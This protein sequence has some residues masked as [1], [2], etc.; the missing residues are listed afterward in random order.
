MS[1]AAT[2]EL[3][4]L[5]AVELKG[6]I[7]GLL[8]HLTLRQT[9]HNPHKV[10][11]ELTHIFPLPPR[12]AVVSCRLKTGK[13]Y[14]SGQLMERRQARQSF[15]AHATRGKTV[16]T[17]E[18]DR[19]DLYTL[20][21]GPIAPGGHLEVELALDLILATEREEVVLS[22]PLTAGRR[23]VPGRPSHGTSA[24]MGTGVDTDI[25]ADASRLNPPVLRP[26][27]SEDSEFHLD[28]SIDS[29]NHD[30]RQVECH[31]HRLKISRR[32]GILRVKNESD[33]PARDFVLRLGMR[34]ENRLAVDPNDATF[35]FTPFWAEDESQRRPLVILLDRSYAMKGQPLADALE[36]AHRLIDS[37]EPEQSFGLLS[38]AN[39]PFH[40][41]SGLVPA[42]PELKLAA[43]Q[44]LQE[45]MAQPG[46]ELCQGLAAVEV[47]LAG[48][49]EPCDLVLLTSAQFG[50]HD[51]LISWAGHQEGLRLHCVA[52]G[53]VV[54]SGLLDRLCC[55]TGGSS[56]RLEHPER[57]DSTYQDL[58]ETLTAARLS[59]LCLIG[60]PLLSA[61]PEHWE[62]SSGRGGSF[63]GRFTEPPTEPLEMIGTLPDGGESSEVITPLEFTHPA[64]PASW[65]RAR[66]LDLEDRWA[67]LPVGTVD[68]TVGG[69]RPAS[70]AAT[71]LRREAERGKAWLER[72]QDFWR[73]KGWLFPPSDQGEPAL[74]LVKAM[75]ESSCMAYGPS[76]VMPG[77][78]P[79][80]SLEE[81]ARELLSLESSIRELSIERGVLCRFT[82]YVVTTGSKVKETAHRVVVPVPRIEER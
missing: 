39:S 52:V 49:S 50:D 46:G 15:Q 73:R 65:A 20:R 62:V 16:C 42:I 58:L 71:H 81:Q 5:V 36:I 4:L 28:L 22:F 57:L 25:V 24:G 47:L 75:E 40:F 76:Q 33:Q 67:G 80:E 8:S 10:P 30:L 45:L 3:P 56:H 68:L 78:S 54:N 82:A 69:D 79:L 51:R 34:A 7:T 31:T 17:L 53:P 43:H 6:R 35:H 74:P 48:K 64:I 23:Y 13:R 14:L 37:L 26:G 18:Q 44:Y 55:L 19:P 9:F 2:A 21:V 12:A 61:S 41:R 70:E 72:V 38:F 11:L 27:D 29:A 59:D 32:Q 77:E 63:H 66:L 1:Q 60:Q